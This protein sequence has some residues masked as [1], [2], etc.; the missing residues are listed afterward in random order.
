MKL[1]PWA[2]F[3]MKVYATYRN[4]RSPE[5]FCF[6]SSWWFGCRNPAS[7]EVDFFASQ[8][9]WYPELG[10]LNSHNH[11]FS[12]KWGLSP[13]HLVTFQKLL[14]LIFYVDEPTPDGSCLI[15]EFFLGKKTSKSAEENKF[16]AL[17]NAVNCLAT[18]PVP[19]FLKIFLAGQRLE[20]WTLKDVKAG[21]NVNIMYP[22]W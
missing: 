2:L 14:R 3:H 17:N 18:L 13:N 10:T 19:Y 20:R 22:F 15:K 9:S 7:W 8:I 16:Q 11:G 21:V 6:I 1:P 12:E 5:L 4:P